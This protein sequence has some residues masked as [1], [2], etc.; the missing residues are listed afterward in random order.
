MD[1][2][3]V[4]KNDWIVAAGF[5]LM[6]IGVSIKWYGASVTVYGVNFG[7]SVSGWHFFLTRIDSLAADSYSRRVGA[8]QGAP[9]LSSACRFLRP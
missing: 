2:S 8:H 6:L 5:I 1:L 4:S 3:K 7:G 9:D